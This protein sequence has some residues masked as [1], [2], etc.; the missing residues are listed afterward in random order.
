MGLEAVEHSAPLRERLSQAFSEMQEPFA[1]AL[2]AAQA[3]GDIRIDVA[4]DKLAGLLL[5]AWYGA[6]LRMKVDRSPVA[7]DLFEQVFLATLLAPP[8]AAPASP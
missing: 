4:A 5:S 1:A 3:A 7:L 8:G 6:M 2:A